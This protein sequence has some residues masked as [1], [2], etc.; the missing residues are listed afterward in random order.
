MISMNQSTKRR[1]STEARVAL[2]TG[3]ASPLGSAICYK[4]AEK[5]IFIAL[6]FGKSREKTLNLQKELSRFGIETIVVMADLGRPSQIRPVIDQVVQKWGRLDL[7]VNNASMFKP[8]P[9]HFKNWE[10]WA[11]F[12]NL[13]SLSPCSLATAAFP[14]LR[15]SKGSIVNITDIYGDLPIL[16]NYSAY[17][18]SKAAL[19]FLTKYLALEFSPTVRVNAVSPGVISFPKD[20]KTKKKKELIQKP[21]CSGR[22]HRKK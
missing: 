18:L 11:E 10:K 6:H 14:W 3:A 17:S 5:G 19:I 12:L 1:N 15:K 9:F 8:N 4:L 7:L 21:L 13:N 2:I 22:G 16:R 20:Y